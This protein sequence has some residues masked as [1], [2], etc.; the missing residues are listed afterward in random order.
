MV[1][2]VEKD[3]QVSKQMIWFCSFFVVVVFVVFVFLLTLFFV[4]LKL[5]DCIW[6]CIYDG[7]GEKNEETNIAAPF[8]I[9]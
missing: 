6:I 2:E 1:G 5:H 3:Q 7:E 4:V 8:Q 9:I